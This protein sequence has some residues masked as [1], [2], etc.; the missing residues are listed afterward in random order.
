MGCSTMAAKEV[1]CLHKC[2]NATGTVSTAVVPTQVQVMNMLA[3]V[4]CL[5]HERGL[6]LVS[7]LQAMI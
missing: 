3:Y 4:W 1:L 2:A 7:I 6:D 5:Q